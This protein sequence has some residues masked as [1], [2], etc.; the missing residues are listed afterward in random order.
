MNTLTYK[1]ILSNN[2]KQLWKLIDVFTAKLII[3]SDNV[4]KLVKI[5]Y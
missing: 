1:L 5:L 4:Q 3:N 2:D